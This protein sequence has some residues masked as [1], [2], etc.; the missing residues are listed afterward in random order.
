MQDVLA[1][2][3]TSEEDDVES[4]AS[5]DMAA[6]E[7]DRA[8]FEARRSQLADW[9][10]SVRTPI[11]QTGVR[12]VNPLPHPMQ[13]LARNPCNP[14]S[15]R[16]LFTSRDEGVILPST[17]DVDLTVNNDDEMIR[18]TDEDIKPE[19]EYWKPALI[20]YILGVKLPFRIIDGFIRRVWGKYGVDKV[21]MMEN[22]VFVVRFQTTGDKN[23]A[24][25][26][27]PI[28]F[29]KLPIIM[30]HWAPDLDLRKE[31][32]MV[33]P[34]WIRLPNLALKYWG[35]QT[36]YKLVC[37]VGKPIKTDRATA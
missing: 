32:V 14:Q 31:D 26:V 35:Q 29:D 28:M 3:W 34:S 30:K 5:L 10:V 18:I 6:T 24:V 12:I 4:H 2:S 21:A 37:K 15:W 20:C 33:V 13:Q 36:L 25:E 17:E 9:L 1:L 27:G 16:S 11:R 19:L 23:R 22:G 7:Q 8:S